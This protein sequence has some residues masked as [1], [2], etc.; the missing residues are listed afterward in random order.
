[1]HVPRSHSPLVSFRLLGALSTTLSL[2]PLHF[3]VQKRVKIFTSALEACKDTEA[4]VVATEWKEFLDI[5]WAEV[6]HNMK[7]PAFIFDGRILLD[8]VKL[9]SIGFEV[10]YI[11]PLILR[12]CFWFL[13]P[14]MALSTTALL[15]LNPYR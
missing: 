9:R 5:D 14:S 7:K 13:C 6:Y 4:V 3:V 11:I 8:A 2:T 1:M 15:T 10:R 12:H